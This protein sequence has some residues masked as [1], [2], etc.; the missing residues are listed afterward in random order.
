MLSNR[1]TIYTDAGRYFRDCEGVDFLREG[2]KPRGAQSTVIMWVTRAGARHMRSPRELCLFC[3]RAQTVVASNSSVVYKFG[4]KHRKGS[5]HEHTCMWTK[6]MYEKGGLMFKY[7]MHNFDVAPV[8][9]SAQYCLSATR[10]E[11]HFVS[12][13]R[14]S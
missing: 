1:K 11:P 8:P 6:Y 12:V 10:Y 7:P 9:Q 5:E 14:E 13:V 4:Q 2:G 3:T